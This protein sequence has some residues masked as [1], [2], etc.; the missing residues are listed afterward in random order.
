VSGVSAGLHALVRLPS[1]VDAQWLL[2]AAAS[3]SVGVYPL[4][5]HMSDPPRETDALVLGYA[6]LAEPAI[7]EGIRKL[8][9]TL[10]EA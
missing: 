1:A 9:Q 5:L 4:S 6:G 7:E 8:A 10:T 2:Q 3:R